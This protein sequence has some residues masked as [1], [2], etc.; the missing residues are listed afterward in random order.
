MFD[1]IFSPTH[2]VSKEYNKNRE[3]EG[4]MQMV[5][6]MLFLIGIIFL[7]DNWVLFI[8]QFTFCR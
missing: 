3:N 5:T 6:Y 1:V 7:S 8:V 2:K 4:N